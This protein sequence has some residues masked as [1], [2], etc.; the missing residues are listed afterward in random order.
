MAEPAPVAPSEQA[1]VEFV[2]AQRWYGSKSREVVRAHIVETVPLETISPRCAVAL[3]EVRFQPGTHE[4]YQLPL[5]YRPAAEGATEGAID[6]VDG[7]TVLDGLAEPAFAREVVDAMRSG[8]TLAGGDG[9]IELRL[10]GSFPAAGDPPSRVVLLGAEQSNS[11]LVL[12]DSLILKVYR[13]L[14]AGIN[15][16][17][18]LLRFLTLH[19]FP[20]IAA[21]R[22]W[23]EYAGRP[24]D[25]TLGLLQDYVPAGSDG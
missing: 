16:E 8:R 18:E 12:D 9:T 19:D 14:E 3:V 6:E 5:A 4:T 22:G 23:Y 15:P 10:T 17:L 11:S 7:W 25:A 1:L 24:I 13:R 20:N 21:L 2:T